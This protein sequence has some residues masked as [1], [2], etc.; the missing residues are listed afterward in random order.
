MEAGHRFVVDHLEGNLAVVE[1]E[2]GPV[3]DLPITMLPAGVQQG[4]VVIAAVLDRTQVSI[5]LRLTIDHDA[6]S[7]RVTEAKDRLERL[8][9][10][11]P[12]GDLQ[13]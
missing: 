12:G 5:T 13:I 3:L 2:G 11:D 10:Q 1:M 6:S 4:S 8:R 9:H 7:S